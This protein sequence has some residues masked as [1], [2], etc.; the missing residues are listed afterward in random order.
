MTNQLGVLADLHESVSLGSVGSS[1]VGESLGSY[2][3]NFVKLNSS[4]IHFQGKCYKLAYFKLPFFCIDP[5]EFSSKYQFFHIENRAKFYR[6][7]P[8]RFEVGVL[9]DDESCKRS[10]SVFCVILQDELKESEFAEMVS[11]FVHLDIFHNPQFPSIASAIQYLTEYFYDFDKIYHQEKSDFKSIDQ[12]INYLNNKGFKIDYE[13]VDLGNII[14]QT[15]S[16]RL[17]DD[18]YAIKVNLSKLLRPSRLAKYFMYE[19][20]LAYT[21]HLSNVKDQTIKVN[22]NGINELY[23]SILLSL[24][25]VS[26]KRNFNSF[27]D[28]IP[29]ILANLWSSS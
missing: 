20:F 13:K 22:C 25:Y 15:T 5:S 9:T 12:C 19:F 2:L 16:T 26:N 10:N 21:N 7:I 11:R 18:T 23:L 4:Q 14:G 3:K 8:D 28:A 24:N 6:T 27:K 1:C 29:K 17:A